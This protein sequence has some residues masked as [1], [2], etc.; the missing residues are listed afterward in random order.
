M[1]TDNQSVFFFVV[2][3]SN[4][5]M[6]FLSEQFSLVFTLFLPF[7]AGLGLSSQT[8]SRSQQKLRKNELF[9]KNLLDF[10][11][12]H[13]FYV[14]LSML[15]EVLTQSSFFKPFFQFHK[16]KNCK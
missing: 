11:I 3:M 4:E 5:S 7:P 10:Y 2:E 15:T 13:D 12:R 6:R 14:V 9:L 1:I 16:K 8:S